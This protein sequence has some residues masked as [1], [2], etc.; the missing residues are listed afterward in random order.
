MLSERV[1]DEETLK[2]LIDCNATQSAI[3][4]KPSIISSL[5]L[6]DFLPHKPFINLRDLFEAKDLG[7]SLF[8]VK[9]FILGFQ[10]QNIR[11]FC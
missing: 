5:Y 9:A 2:S 4:S 8:R 10:P 1:I 3:L 7:D 11:E 6:H